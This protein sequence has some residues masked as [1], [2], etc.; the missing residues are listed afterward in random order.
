MKRNRQ[1]IL[2]FIL[3]AGLCVGLYGIS[4]NALIAVS[5]I[6]FCSACLTFIFN[7]FTKEY[8]WTD[9]LWSTLPIFMAWIYYF[10]TPNAVLLITAGLATIWGIRLTFNFSRKGGYN[11]KED[12][13]WAYLRKKLGSGFVWQIFSLFFIAFYQQAL[14]VGFTSPLFLISKSEV[15]SNTFTYIFALLAIMFL[16]LET[17]ADQQQWVFQESKYGRTLK[18]EKF[19]K[20]YTLG[21]RISGLFSISRHPNY[22]GELG[23]WWSIYLLCSSTVGDLINLTIIG[24]VLLTL[25]FVGSVSFTEGISREKYKDYNWYRKKV[26]PVFPLVWKRLK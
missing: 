4:E 9:R 18:K 26:S 24:P 14:F 15:K 11:E 5:I 6:V 20:D 22:L 1:I 16:V 19:A 8:S 25:L 23:F 10:K 13:R 3:I 21:F 17:V 12:Y 7:V 2:F